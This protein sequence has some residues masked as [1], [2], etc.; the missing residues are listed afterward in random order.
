MIL[1]CAI[2]GILIVTKCNSNGLIFIIYIY[3]CDCILIV[4]VNVTLYFNCN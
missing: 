1:M 2:E 4:C 3:Y